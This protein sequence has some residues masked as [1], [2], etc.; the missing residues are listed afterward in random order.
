VV[1]ASEK[2][3]TIQLVGF[4]AGGKQFGV[5]ILAIREILRHAALEPVQNAPPFV[6]GGI[7]IRGAVIPAIDLKKRLG[8][9]NPSDAP[10]RSW[11]LIVRVG[12]FDVGFLV[13]SVTRILKVGSEDILPAPD[14]TLCGMRSQYIQGVCNS[15]TDM[16]VVLDLN[17]LLATDEM[18]ALQKTVDLHPA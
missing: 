9:P 7:R 15:E 11:A 18:K 1:L 3:N 12:N 2:E 10:D 4:R 16:L 8:K 17:R 13:D 14:L 6:A 5:N